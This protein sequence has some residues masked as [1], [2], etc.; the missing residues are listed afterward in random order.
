MKQLW[1]G[2]GY[3]ANVV[4]YSIAW[5][6]NKVFSMKKVIDFSKIWETQKISK[7][8]YETLVD[9]SYQIHKIITDTPENIS[10]VTEWCKKEGCWLKVK[11]FDMDLSEAFISELIGKEM[12]A[13]DEKDAK[14]VQKI[15]D[16]INAQKKVLNLGPE[17]WKELSVWGVSRKLLNEKDMGIL[18]V[19]VR[20]PDKIPSEKQSMHLM[21]LLVKME[22]EGFQFE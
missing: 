16:G 12:A 21:K 20:I 19:A 15:D 5:M 11:A 8:F 7:A 18:Q 13:V 1:Y 10:N 14:K 9:V 3:R 6:A 22:V 2:G 4:V 17:K